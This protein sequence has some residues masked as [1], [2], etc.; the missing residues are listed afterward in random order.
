[1]RNSTVG[2]A[3]EAAF[4]IARFFADFFL[5]KVRPAAGEEPHEKIEIGENREPRTENRGKKSR[6][7]TM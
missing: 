5:K 4:R 1:M 2:V 7:D 3:S 6:I